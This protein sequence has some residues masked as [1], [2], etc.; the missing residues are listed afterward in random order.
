MLVEFC[1]PVKNE[2]SILQNNALKIKDFLSQ[3]RPSYDWRIIILVNGSDD[4]SLTIAQE[5]AA[6]DPIHFQ[7]RF[8]AKG[9]KGLAL[10][11]Y[12]K[13]S[14]AE[15]LVFIDIDMAVPLS[16]LDP[17]LYPLLTDQADLVVGSRLLPG[18]RVNRPWLRGLSSHIYNYLARLFFDYQ[19]SDLQCGFKALKRSLFNRLQPYL[20]DDQWFLDTELIIF[21]HYFGYRLAEIPV[22]WEE[23]RYKSRQSKIKVFSDSF[24]FFRNL[25]NLKKR[26]HALEHD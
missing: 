6:S 21:A 19:I 25:L 11:S 7:A 15:L 2:E 1:L 24:I 14:S 22:D 8:L 9:G 18:A 10:K 3:H 12:F 5:L 23:R 20:L 26:L 16:N 4:S 17:L 13:D